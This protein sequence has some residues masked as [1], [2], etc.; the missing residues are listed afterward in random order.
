[1]NLDVK[2]NQ[3]NTII[4]IIIA[5]IIDDEP[6][7]IRYNFIAEIFMIVF[8]SIIKISRRTKRIKIPKQYIYDVG[9]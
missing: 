4:I 2:V 6:K 8:L 5:I 1:M 9:F 3:Q 7:A